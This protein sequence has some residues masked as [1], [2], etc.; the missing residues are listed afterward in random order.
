V[1]TVASDEPFA[2]NF[3][4]PYSPPAMSRVSQPQQFDLW[5]LD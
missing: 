3:I 1:I 5:S 2:E 4:P